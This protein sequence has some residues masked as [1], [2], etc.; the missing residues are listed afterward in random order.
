MTPRCGNRKR[1]PIDRNWPTTRREED[2]LE[3]IYTI[4]SE[5]GVARSTDVAN[6][7]QVRSPCVTEMFG[8]LDRKGLV[9]YRKYEGVRLTAEGTRIGK[10]VKDRHDSLRTFLENIDVREP[11]ASRDACVLEH[12]LSPETIMQIKMFN[13]FVAMAGEEGLLWLNDFKHLSRQGKLP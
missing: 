12:D 7:L 5:K 11:F 8:K 4:Q 3:A 10:A 6:H 1:M 2:Y 13:S 9:V